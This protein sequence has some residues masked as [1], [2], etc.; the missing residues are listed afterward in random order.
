MRRTS[1]LAS[2]LAAVGIIAAGL[3]AATPA[4]ANPSPTNIFLTASNPPCS[5]SDINVTD[6]SSNPVTSITGTAGSIGVQNQCGVTV[7]VSV[8]GSTTNP[9]DVGAGFSG[10]FA[11]SSG[12]TTLQIF[13][14]GGGGSAW[15]TIPIALTGGGGGGGAGGDEEAAPVPVALSLDVNAPTSG[16]T[17]KGGSS[18]I[19]YTGEWLTLPASGDCTLAGK[20]GAVLL[21]WSTSASFPVAIAQRQ[22]TNKWGTYE[23][24]D[25]DGQ[26][27]AVFIPAGWETLV[28]GA[29]LLHLI[30]S[31]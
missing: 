2:V 4:S 17:C 12:T 10:F 11:L 24:T 31:S 30:W 20:P 18:V 27:T 13:Q 3:A 29:N 6:V 23:L 19:G 14:A 15:V 22:A 16:T 25:A 28:A 26:V 21:G 5:S 7:F 9:T 1:R 8:P